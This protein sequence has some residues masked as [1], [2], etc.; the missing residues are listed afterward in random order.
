[1]NGSHVTHKRRKFGR[2]FSLYKYVH[3]LFIHA[4]TIADVSY[5]IATIAIE[6][7]HLIT[8]TSLGVSQARRG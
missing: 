1:M 6:V 7:A 2:H 4:L 5:I 8:V 3:E